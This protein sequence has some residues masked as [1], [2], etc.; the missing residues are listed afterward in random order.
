MKYTPDGKF[1]V[2]AGEQR[3]ELFAWD[4]STWELKTRLDGPVSVIQALSTAAN[5]RVAFMR[6]EGPDE[7]PIR[8]IIV[9]DLITDRT[10][11]ERTSTLEEGGLVLRPDGKQLA[12]SDG[13]EWSLFTIPGQKRR[14]KLIG[15]KLCYSKDSR[16]VA[17]SRGSTLLVYDANTLKKQWSVD[18]PEGHCPE[19]LAFTA[20]GP[21]LTC[22]VDEGTLWK[23]EPASGTVSKIGGEDT[24]SFITDMSPTGTFAA[25]VNGMMASLICLET[26]LEAFSW[27][28][29][30]LWLE[31]VALDPRGGYAAT[32]GYGPTV[33]VF[34]LPSKFYLTKPT[35]EVDQTLSVKTN[36]E[37]LSMHEGKLLRGSLLGKW[38]P[39]I[40][41]EAP[42]VPPKVER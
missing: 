4:T 6:M 5:G 35:P 38:D 33:N 28:A 25:G 3:G 10:I 29:G 31:A 26:G 18:L 41:G 19:Y 7:A 16:W 32:C 13:N 2:A 27:I 37:V 40:I 21:V 39:V 36:G 1:L 23:V 14:V 9:H 8:R 11:V 15:E 17:V 30:R 22:F 24:Y 34:K 42:D 12:I 20:K